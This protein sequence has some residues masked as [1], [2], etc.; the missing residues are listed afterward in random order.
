M[1]ESELVMVLA[2]AWNTLDSSLLAPYLADGVV[3]ESQQVLAPLVG[4]EAVL[5]HL[6]QK[7][8]SLRDAP[9][10]RK[11]YCEIGN[12]GSQRGMRVMVMSAV[13]GKP[14]VVLAIGNRDKPVALVL[15][16]TADCLIKRVDIST[17]VPHPSTA[18]RSGEYPA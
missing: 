16:E 2:K 1:T 12:C 3:Y 8:L 15:L 11:Y 10:D 14:C 7:M 6:H 4:K 17:V 9:A 18:I 5:D 13:E